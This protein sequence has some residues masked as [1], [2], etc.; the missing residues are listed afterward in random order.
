MEKEAL[1]WGH[2]LSGMDMWDESSTDL[3]LQSASMGPCPFRHGYRKHELR[4]EKKKKRFNGA[5]P[6]Q[7][8]IYGNIQYTTNA[9][10]LLQW[11][12][13]LSGMDIS[14][15]GEIIEIDLDA[16]MGPCPFR[17]GYGVHTDPENP[18][19]VASMGPC[20]FRHGYQAREDQRMRMHVCFNGAMPFQAWIY[21]WRTSSI[22]TQ[23]EASMGPCPF[24]HGYAYLAS[25]QGRG[26]RRFNGAMPF[27]AWISPVF[28]GHAFSPAGASMGPCPFRHGYISSCVIFSIHG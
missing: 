18:P 27:Q 6:F 14:E 15:Y 7:A 26:E 28:A 1:Q 4:K 20:P 2:A 3:F 16:S 23:A 25:H 12:H 17:H 22:L 21:R 11:G 19:A 9:P 13:A 5:M 10:Y 24:R 8:W